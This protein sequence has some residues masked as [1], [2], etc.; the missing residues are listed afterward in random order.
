MTT[1]NTI[2]EEEIE[3]LKAITGEQRYALQKKTPRFS[4]NYGDGTPFNIQGIV[5]ACYVDP[6]GGKHLGDNLELVKETHFPLYSEEAAVKLLTERGYEVKAPPEPLKGKVVVYR[7]SVGEV[8]TTHKEWWDKW[9]DYVKGPLKLIA[10]V[11][12]TEGQGI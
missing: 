7:N 1:L 8:Y 2:I 3:E 11:D 4:P 12:W 9:T 10:I 5:D 6:D